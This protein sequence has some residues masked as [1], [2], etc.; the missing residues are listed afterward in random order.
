MPIARPILAPLTTILADHGDISLYMDVFFVNQNA[1]FHTIS[2]KIQFRTV[3]AIDD[4][5]KGTL[6]AGTNAVLGVYKARV[7]RAVINVQGDREFACLCCDL[8]HIITNIVDTNNHVPEV[9]RSIRTIKDRVRSTIHGLPFKCWPRLMICA[10]VEA[11]VRN[12][13]MFPATT[14]VSATLSPR[15]I[16]TGRG[17][18]D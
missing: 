17:P 11:A 13:N 7:F 5:T 18:P 1:F 10:A 2:K 15:T 4:R 3:V 16:L 9:E 8:D 12:L 14:G 6:L